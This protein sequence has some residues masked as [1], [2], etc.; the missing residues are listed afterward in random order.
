MTFIDSHCH[1]DFPQFFDDLSAVLDSARENGVSQ[2][3]VPGVKASAWLSQIELCK[4]NRLHFALGLHPY[5]LSEYHPSNIVLLKQLINDNACIAVGECGIDLTYP[6]IKLQQSIFIEH[7]KVA[8]EYK[9][10][11]I[12]H[13]RRS[14]HL[15]FECFKQVKPECGGVI[16]AFSGS[17]QD[18]DKYIQ[19]GFSLGVGGVISYER[20]IKTRQVIQQVPLQNIILETDSPD[21]PLSGLQ[22]QRNEP[23][24]IEKVAGC[25]ANLRSESLEKIAAQSTQNVIKLFNL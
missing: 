23:K 13:H 1:L 5:F 4:Q 12:V 11:L 20:A 14:H 3:I 17:R 9:L 8:N 6:D 21:M 22:G 15:I 10:P 24:N 16:H 19:L 25:L 2:F 18:A 7:I